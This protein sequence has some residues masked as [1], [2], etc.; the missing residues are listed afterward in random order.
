MKVKAVDHFAVTVS[1]TERA[2]K[3]YVGLLGL[4]QVEQHLLEGEGCDKVCGHKNTRGQS[5]RLIVEGTPDIL[6][7]LL[8]LFHP[9]LEP[10]QPPFD[11]VGSCHLAFTVE[12]LPGAVKELESKGVKFTSE[13]VDFEITT[14]TVTV[15]FCQDPDGN[16]VEF[17]EEYTR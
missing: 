13:P 2:L 6:I 14:G 17:M 15:C 4:K 8:E 10:A 3:F 5:T 12:D 16:Y 11:A 7:D 9:Q 1:D